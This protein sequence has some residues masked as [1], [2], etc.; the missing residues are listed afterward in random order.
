MNR[1]TVSLFTALLG[2][3]VCLSASAAE[4][5][6][7][8]STAKPKARNVDQPRCV[9]PDNRKQKAPVWVCGEAPKGQ[10]LFATGSAARAKGSGVQDTK[11]RAVAEARLKLAKQLSEQVEL[12]ANRHAT[13]IGVPLAQAGRIVTPA[14]AKKSQEV[15]VGSKIVESITSRKGAIYVVVGLDAAK[16]DES[17]AATVKAAAGAEPAAWQPLLGGKPAELL[18]AQLAAVKLTN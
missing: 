4:P 9:F 10:A 11:D 14:L 7:A 3:A 12:R 2:S 17:V 15:L 18:G 1:I 8:T 13:A 6:K 16:L 5:A